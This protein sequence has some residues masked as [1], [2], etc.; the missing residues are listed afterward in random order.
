MTSL[1]P[2]DSDTLV[3]GSSDGGQTVRTDDVKFN[4]MMKQVGNILNLKV[5]SRGSSRKKRKKRK[6]ESEKRRERIE[7]EEG[8]KRRR[9]QAQINLILVACCHC[10]LITLVLITRLS[11]LVL[12]WKVTEEET[13]GTIIIIIV[14]IIVN[15]VVLLSYS[16]LLFC[17]THKA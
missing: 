2:I 11:A 14:I 1:L 6:C 16:L 5:C 10:S 4:Q 8:E 13:E 15:S 7:G 3:Y 17:R 9:E 12:T